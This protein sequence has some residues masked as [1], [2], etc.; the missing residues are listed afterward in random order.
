MTMWRQGRSQ[1]VRRPND[2]QLD[3]DKT[4]RRLA[5]LFWEYQLRGTNGVRRNYRRSYTSLS[6]D[7]LNVNT[8][9]GC[10]LGPSI[11]GAPIGIPGTESPVTDGRS[12]SN[13]D[14]TSAG[15]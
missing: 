9:Y 10:G 2:K 1:T 15:T 8:V 5:A 13:R 3:V 11:P 12:F 4:V 7:S 6:P 14:T